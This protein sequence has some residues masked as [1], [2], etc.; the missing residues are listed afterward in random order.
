MINN[1]FTRLYT[2]INTLISAGNATL[3]AIFNKI[4]YPRPSEKTGR[5][6]ISIVGKI[7]LSTTVYTVTPG[8]TLYLFCVNSISRALLATSSHHTVRD[9]GAAGT[10]IAQSGSSL[11]VGASNQILLPSLVEPAIFTTDVRI[12]LDAGTSGFLAYNFIGYEE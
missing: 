6:H 7:T 11:A 8:K 4:Y 10:I 1:I 12:E 9:G 2:L 5:T 3:T